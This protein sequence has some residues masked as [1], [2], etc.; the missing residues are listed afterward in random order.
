MILLVCRFLYP[1]F[2]SRPDTICPRGMLWLVPG[3]H[4]STGQ[5]FVQERCLFLNF[6]QTDKN[7]A[8]PK[9][10]SYLVV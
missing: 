10:R 7:L 5:M 3:K 1:G 2:F 6:C 4:Q 8:S 9:C